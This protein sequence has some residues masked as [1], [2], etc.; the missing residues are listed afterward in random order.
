MPDNIDRIITKILIAL[1]FAGAAL[2]LRKE[3]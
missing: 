3:W 2:W 1:S